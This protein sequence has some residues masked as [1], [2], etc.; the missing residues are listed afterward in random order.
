MPIT[1]MERFGATSK[2][3]GEV[4]GDADAANAHPRSQRLV[5]GAVAVAA[6]V[7]FVLAGRDWPRETDR[8]A[9]T[10]QVRELERRI[11]SRGPDLWLLVEGND[12]QDTF[13]TDREARHQ[14]MLR[15]F[16]RLSHVEGFAITDI[17]VHV[18]GDSALATYRIRSLSAAE[19]VPRGGQL[20]FI[21][22]KDRWTITGH[23]F[24]E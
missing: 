18:D 14:A 4:A 13:D 22:G 11:R 9:V 6:L 1:P 21:R 23:R 15:D 10:A 12:S 8:H 17:M 5:L 20:H 16:E 19:P 7:G 3:T 24:T 2:A